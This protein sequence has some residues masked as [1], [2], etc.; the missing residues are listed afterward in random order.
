MTDMYK[1]AMANNAHDF[2]V[3]FLQRHYPVHWAC[4]QGDETSLKEL[5]TSGRVD[6]YQ[7]DGLHGWTPMHWA[8]SRGQWKCLQLI[9]QICQ[10]DLDVTITRTNQTLAHIAAQ[11]SQAECIAWLVQHGISLGI[12]DHNGDTPLHKA[13]QSGHLECVKLL[14]TP[15]PV[16]STYNQNGQT[17]LD[18]AVQHGH[19][20]CKEFLEQAMISQHS[21]FFPSA[22]SP[23]LMNGE[24]IYQHRV[25][26]RSGIECDQDME[27]GEEMGSDGDA[28]TL[29]QPVARGKRSYDEEEEVSFK[30][31]RLFAPTSE[32]K[33]GTVNNNNVVSSYQGILA[34][35]VEPLK[36][37]AHHYLNDSQ[38]VHAKPPSP[39]AWSPSDV[40]TSGSSSFVDHCHAMQ[41]QQGYESIMLSSLIHMDH[42]S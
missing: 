25:L 19:Q 12:Q 40:A 32:E 14:T 16:L 18:V 4:F 22:S 13:A 30:R 21:S 6:I 10:V 11:Q 24:G 38:E 8:A 9:G 39:S 35:S 41:A 29:F 20:E 34:M 37:P 3:E 27:M 31:R 23:I 33:V 5:F 26:G 7:E 42:G 2:N 1:S 36:H 15:S 17:A 28:A